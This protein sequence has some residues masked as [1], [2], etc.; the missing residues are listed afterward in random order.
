[1]KNE[2][3]AN[4]LFVYIGKYIINLFNKRSITDNIDFF[5]FYGHKID[6]LKCILPNF[7]Q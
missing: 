5:F 3:L 7:S 6:F 1:M 2:N 4:N